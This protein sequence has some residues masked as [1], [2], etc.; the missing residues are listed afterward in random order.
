MTEPSRPVRVRFAPS[1]TGDLHIGGVRTAMFNW[2]FAK[3]YG[4]KFILRIEDTDQTR[5][6]EGSLDGIMAGL[7]WAGLLWD[8]GPDSGG[9]YAPYIQSQRVELY[10]KWA[11]WL[12]ENGKAYRAYDSDDELELM[13]RSGTG[14]DRRGRYLS[15]EDIARYEA[16]GRKPVIRFKVPLDE[17]IVV[18][19]LVRDP[20]RVDSNTIQDAVLLKS[21]GFPTYHLAN[22][23]D[24]HFM[25]ISHIIRA[26]EWISSAPLHKM[27]YDA[28][29]WEMPAIA[30][31]PVILKQNGKGKMSKRDEG[32][33]ISYFMEGGYLPEAVTNYLC[34]VGWSYNQY[35]AEGKEIQIFSKEEA[36]AV[37]DI[38]RVSTTGTKFDLVKLQWLNGEYIRL[39]EANKLAQYLRPYLEAAGYEV[40]VD[41]LLKV[42]PLIRERL[43]TLK[44]VVSAA[45]FFFQDEVTPTVELLIPKKMTAEQTVDTLK[46]ANTALAALTEWTIPAIEGALRSLAEKLG[47]SAGQLFS[48]I[49]AATSGQPVSPPLFETLEVVGRD[50][51]LKRIENAI[52]LLQKQTA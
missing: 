32:A 38:T 27:L 5:F 33:A 37:F 8:E 42:I 44:D 41:T 36:A 35:D 6:K 24:D 46:H 13:R 7:R 17:T 50:L 34:N 29:G 9:P 14:Y 45:G 23:I 21:D 30:H 10:Q 26:E 2:L 15:A 39:M 18:N 20:I 4:G 19:D 48:P 49:R 40:N 51:T 43:K 47:L 11:N 3:H 1:P 25:E 12:L 52:K 16:E 22:V 31:V 28:F